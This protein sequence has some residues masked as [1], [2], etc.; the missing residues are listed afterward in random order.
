[1]MAVGIAQRMVDASA[2]G[3][4]FCA[5][6]AGGL[7]RIQLGLAQVVLDTRD[8]ALKRADHGELPACVLALHGQKPLFDRVNAASAGLE[9]A[10]DGEQARPAQLQQGI[11]GVPCSRQQV[12]P[13]CDHIDFT[14]VQLQ[15]DIT[16]ENPEDKLRIIACKRMVKG[17]FR[18]LLRQIP[19][20]GFAMQGD[21]FMRI[22]AM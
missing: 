20:G 10:C 6:V 11:G 21:D 13:A 12:E 16:F 5:Q 4:A 7:M 2:K 9:R 3:E 15:V 22:A 18:Q 17:R 14:G 1:M 19:A 8:K